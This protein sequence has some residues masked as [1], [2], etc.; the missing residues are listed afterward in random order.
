VIQRTELCTRAACK[1]EWKSASQQ[2]LCY[3]HFRLLFGWIKGSSGAQG[4]QKLGWKWL[5]DERRCSV[6]G[7]EGAR[8]SRTSR[9][10]EFQ[11]PYVVVVGHYAV[12]IVQVNLL[13]LQCACRTRP[14]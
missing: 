2:E 14:L 8:E 10:E 12:N 5:F 13:H 4:Q 7:A 1:A 3:K 11:N 9:R 6:S